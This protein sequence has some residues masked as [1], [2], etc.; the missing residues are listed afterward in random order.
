MSQE[1]LYFLTI[2]R[3]RRYPASIHCA[4]PKKETYPAATVQ[5]NAI[6]LSQGSFPFWET[7]R[8]S[9]REAGTGK[10]T[11]QWAGDQPSSPVNSPGNQHEA[12]SWRFSMQRG[13][14]NCGYSSIDSWMNLV[15]SIYPITNIHQAAH[16]L[17]KCTAL[18]NNMYICV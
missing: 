13:R 12:N 11:F 2:H 3:A 4:W 15:H 8:K 5:T 10:T 9:S 7:C 1:L 16:V 17:Q 14:L 6:P 18:E